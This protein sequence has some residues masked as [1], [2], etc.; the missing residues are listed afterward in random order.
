MLGKRLHELLLLLKFLDNDGLISQFV[1]TT[2]ILEWV[3]ALP[4]SRDA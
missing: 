1:K 3:C 4:A 2:L